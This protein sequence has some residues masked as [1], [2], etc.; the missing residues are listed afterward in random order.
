[1]AA[2]ITQLVKRSKVPPPSLLGNSSLRARPDGR[3]S[4]DHPGTTEEESSHLALRHTDEG[5]NPSSRAHDR[6]RH[7]ALTLTAASTDERRMSGCAEDGE[8]VRVYASGGGG[9]CGWGRRLVPG[10]RGARRRVSSLA[11]S[12]PPPVPPRTATHPHL[13]HQPQDIWSADSLGIS[14]SPAAPGWQRSLSSWVSSVDVTVERAHAGR[15]ERRHRQISTE[16]VS[17]IFHSLLLGVSDAE[18]RTSRE[19]DFA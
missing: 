15:D 4:L 14:S 6:C 10:R 16:T 18:T 2:P 8:D 12:C 17:S 3:L 13:L 19:G 9:R 1:M 7:D 5:R 11:S